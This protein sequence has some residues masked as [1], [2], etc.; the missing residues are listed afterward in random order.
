MSS[1]N[2]LLVIGSNRAENFHCMLSQLAPDRDIRLHGQHGNPEDIRAALAWHPPVGA[3]KTFP[4]LELIVSVG[5]GVDHIFRDPDLPN[6]TIVRYVDPDLTNRMTDYVVLHTLLH[7]RR[8]TEY[9]ANQRAAQ[10]I[11]IPEPAAHEIRVGIMGIGTL[12]QNAARAL[13][14]LGF[15]VNGWS[16]TPKTLDGITHFAGEDNLDAFLHA[17]DILVVLLPLTPGT[18]GIIN[19]DLLQKLSRTGRHPRLPGPV[20][21]NAGRGGLQIE[22]DILASLDDGTMYAASLD[23]FETE[24]L[25]ASSPFWAHPRVVVTPHNAAESTDES[26]SKYFLRQIDRLEA[27]TTPEN[28]VDPSAG[29]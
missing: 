13:K 10:W 14:A 12:G 27:G 8:Q 2:A 15:Q 3:L 16:R 28:I 6:A 17:T 4:N 23:V 5:A 1:P 21:I 11:Y 24:P 25:P 20:L 18:R 19:K 7:T 26:I 9:Q 29:Y 22:S